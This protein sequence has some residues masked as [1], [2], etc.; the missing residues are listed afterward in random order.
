MKPTFSFNEHYV[1]RVMYLVPVLLT[2]FWPDK[3]ALWLILA[4]VCRFGLEL[5]E[6]FAFFACDDS[7]LGRRF[8]AGP[9]EDEVTL[10]AVLLHPSAL[11]I[12]LVLLLERL[13][14]DYI[15]DLTR[16]VVLSISYM[17]IAIGLFGASMVN[18]L[19]DPPCDTPLR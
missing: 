19:A 3:L 18:D 6:M 10:L 15:S 4:L 1:V 9:N 7:L 16:V 14:F 2:L 5:A 11:W 8:T 17:F 13:T 12:L